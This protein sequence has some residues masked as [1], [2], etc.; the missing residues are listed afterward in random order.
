MVNFF[1]SPLLLQINFSVP[2]DAGSLSLAAVNKYT[3]SFPFAA[4]LPVQPLTYLPV[5]MLDGNPAVKV[6]FL[7][8]KTAEKGSEDG[9]IV[10]SSGLV[11]VE[12]YDEEGE[13]NSFKKTIELTAKRITEGQT[14]SKVFS[15]K[16]IILAFVKGLNEKR[17]EEIL[18]EG[19]NIKVDS[20][21]HLWM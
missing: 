2:N 1:H 8:K 10:F 18:M 14:V 6:T 9:G 19:G 7:R 20:I 17:G 3:Q 13:F 5:K 21:F 15:E 16:Q 11:S 12:D 4:V